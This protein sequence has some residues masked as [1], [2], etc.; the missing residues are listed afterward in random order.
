M[1]YLK[2]RWESD[3]DGT[4]ELF[5]EFEAN[6]F[7]G[8]GSAWFDKISLI[9]K[10]KN[11][12]DYPISDEK[13]PTIEG[14]FWN[15]KKDAGLSQ[16]HLHISVYPID[17]RGNLG[18]RIRVAEELWPEDRKNSQHYVGVEIVTNYKDIGKFAK[19]IRELLSREID[20]AILYQAKV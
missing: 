9:E 4:G 19:N 20:E 11:F 7:S 1:N 13:H 16:E 8:H 10:I 15:E 18:V 3:D 6:G 12:E 14:G 17:S 5:A 2:L